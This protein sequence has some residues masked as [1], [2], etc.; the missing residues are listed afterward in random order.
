[1]GT[2]TSSVSR[3]DLEGLYAAALDNHLR[4]GDETHLYRGYELGRSAL[5]E[6]T[7][8]LDMVELH[9]RSLARILSASQSVPD[10]VRSVED[11]TVF[12]KEA[13]SSY[14]MTNRAFGEANAA[15]QRF[16]ETLEVQVKRIA[17]ALHDESGQL[18]AVVYIKLEEVARNMP[19]EIREQLHEVR[20]L[21]DQV[22]A[23]LRLLS[24]ELRPPVLDDQGLLPALENLANIVHNRSGLCVT[25]ESS[26]SVRLPKR[27]ET[28]F[29]RV[30][31]EGLTN[32]AKHSH[33][34]AV[35]VRLWCEPGT[36]CCCIEDD[37]IGFDA[38]AASDGRAPR[39]LGLTGMREQ[40]QTLGGACDFQSAPGQGTRLN[41]RVPMES[42]MSI[43]ILLA[44]DHQII[45]DGMKA[46]L[47][48]EGFKVNAEAENGQE[49][50]R[51][52]LKLRPDVAVLDIAMPILNGLDAAR[53]ILNSVAETKIVILTIHSDKSYVLEGLRVGVSGFVTKTHA[54]RDLVKAIRHALQ[55]KTYLSPELSQI[56]FE[57]LRARHDVVQDPLAPKE[58]QVLQLIAEGKTNKE[59]A[60]LLNI[61]A[62]T[63]ATH[64]A[65]IMKKLDIHE[66]AGLV[67][68]A[69]RRGLIQ[70]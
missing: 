52:A 6:G 48:R 65:R 12:F 49:A 13:M 34:Q 1:M 7:S 39:G 58:R 67:R 46:F 10:P 11:A 32:A 50:A 37:G 14:E 29:Y 27:I 18:L 9:G 63:A 21:V 38:E 57:A 16:N 4:Q 70:P 35:K 44:D 33:A 36:A 60:H 66:T 30:I 2:K 59:T 64:R 23:Q 19:A 24:H 40:L 31:Q 53:E 5:R 17:S 69:V 26:D 43:Q 56:I 20:Q 62:K 42:E 68:Y 55:D 61:T 28:V 15:L 41:V 3:T 8:I 47:E 22:E 25:L 51:L 54:A 45:R